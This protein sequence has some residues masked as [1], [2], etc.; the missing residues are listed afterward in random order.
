MDRFD[1]MSVFV[2]VTKEGSFS[3]AARKLG[4][5]LATVSRKVSDLESHLGV[6]LLNRTTRRLDLT[7]TG[8][9]FLSSCESILE[10]VEEA[11]K[12]ATGEYRAP[13]G[14]LFISAPL[15]FGRLHIV[16]LVSEFLKSYPDIKIHLI[17]TDRILN[18]IEENIDLSLRIGH[19]Q[20]SSM[21][22]SKVGVT[23][24]VTCASPAYLASRGTP[25]K[26]S[27]LRQHECI[28]IESFG[29]SMVWKFQDGEKKLSVPIDSRLITS[30]VESGI[31]SAISGVGIARAFCYQID[32][33][34]KNKKLKTILKPYGTPPIPINLLYSGSRNTPQKLR[35]FLDFSIPRLKQAIPQK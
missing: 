8:R 26:P 22:A 7:E 11:E 27:D 18:L 34:M 9:S 10:K 15:I 19:L 32:A 5:P 4:T 3:A 24:L 12:I 2:A 25:S 29:S 28:S 14:T 31:A 13:K 6:K 20:D 17:L 35:S 33:P 21:V 23:R 30:D 1:A 16:P